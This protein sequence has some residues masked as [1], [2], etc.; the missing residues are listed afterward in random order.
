MHSPT[1]LCAYSGREH[2]AI[3]AYRELRVRLLASA[4][5]RRQS[6]VLS[7]C[8]ERLQIVTDSIANRKGRVIALCVITVLILGVA[9]ALWATCHVAEQRYGLS[10][11][12]EISHE[13][14]ADNACRVRL[15]IRP[16]LLLP[17][18]DHY[19]PEEG[20]APMIGPPTSELFR[21][22]LPREIALLVR[23]DLPSDK[24]YLTLFANEQYGGPY[25]QT[26]INNANVLAS[27][28][29]V[30]WTSKGLE[31]RERGALVAEGALALPESLEPLALQE[32]FE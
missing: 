19:L 29:G 16:E 4:W 27:V 3:P 17:Y 6:H 8:I 11:A 22:L 9:T 12:P 25:M 24:I 15:V 18:L 5:R 1:V 31:L 10:P 7:Y 2:F 14:F 20:E 28:P 30:Q 26:Q 32:S 23:S 21:R 13:Q